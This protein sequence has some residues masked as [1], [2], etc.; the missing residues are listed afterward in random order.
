[1]EN[2]TTVS[3]P[4]L[5]LL[6]NQALSVAR[7]ATVVCC[8]SLGKCRPKWL[9]CAEAQTTGTQRGAAGALCASQQDEGQR[10]GLPQ[11]SF[12]PRS[13]LDLCEGWAAGSRG[14]WPAFSPTNAL[15]GQVY[16]D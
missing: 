13:G 10:P 9:L 4:P 5:S 11:S 3:L 16:K 15:S 6:F 7:A 1:M 12:Q 8:L 14:G 2:A